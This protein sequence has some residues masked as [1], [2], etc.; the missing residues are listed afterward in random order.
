MLSIINGQVENYVSQFGCSELIR[1]SGQPCFTCD[2]NKIPSLIYP[3]LVVDGEIFDNPH[4][5]NLKDQ[6]RN[7]HK[8]IRLEIEIEN[9]IVV[10]VKEIIVSDLVSK[11]LKN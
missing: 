2:L 1:I 11:R 7:T 3:R 10:I 6:Y 8:I 4:F 5:D 9:N